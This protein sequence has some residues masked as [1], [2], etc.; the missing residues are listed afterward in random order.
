MDADFPWEQ[1]VRHARDRL[2]RVVESEGHSKKV[3]GDVAFHMTDWLHD[4]H[5]LLDVLDP[6]SRP[7]DAEVTKVLRDFLVH[8]PEHVAAA[9]KLYLSR[10]ICDTFG[11]SVCE[12]SDEN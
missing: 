6:H 7:T 11:L 8:V 12:G 5:D 2:T 4:L 9:A 10:G 1:Y 3:A